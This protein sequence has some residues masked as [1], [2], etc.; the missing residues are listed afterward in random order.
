M[1]KFRTKLVPNTTSKKKDAYDLLVS[2]GGEPFK[3]HKSGI[4][5][6]EALRESSTFG[7]KNLWLDIQK[8]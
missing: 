6:E 2:E 3:V 5:L 1:K 4:T 7:Y 8:K